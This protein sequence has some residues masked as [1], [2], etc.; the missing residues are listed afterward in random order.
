MWGHTGYRG[1]AWRFG[2]RI[3]ITIKSKIRSGSGEGEGSRQ[4][5]RRS[6]GWG[7]V[8]TSEPPEGGTAYETSGIATW[9]WG[10]N[11]VWEHMGY[12]GRVWRFGGRI[13]IKIKSRI[14]SGSGSGEGVVD[15]LAVEAASRWLRQRLRAVGVSGGTPLPLSGSIVCGGFIASR[16]RGWAWVRG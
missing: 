13:R 5:C 14:R 11:A 15:L 2:G 4:G 16:M 3:R 10:G 6:Q 8:G 12:R 1:R 7:G 9:G